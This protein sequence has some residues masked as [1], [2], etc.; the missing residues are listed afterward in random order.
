MRRV[1]ILLTGL[2]LMAVLPAV[3]FAQ[4]SYNITG[5]APLSGDNFT[6]AYAVNNSDQIVGISANVDLSGSNTFNSADVVGLLVSGSTVTTLPTLGTNQ[7]GQSYTFPTDINN[8]G[9]VV[10]ISS[11]A[12]TANGV[13]PF[14]YQ[15]GVIAQLGGTAFSSY[16]TAGAFGVNDSGVVVGNARTKSASTSQTDGFI[17]NGSLKTVG[18][19]SGATQTY[20]IGINASGVVVGGSGSNTGGHAFVYDGSIHDLGALPG[21][22]LSSATSINSQGNIVG[23]SASSTSVPPTSSPTQEIATIGLGA[24]GALGALGNDSVGNAFFYDSTTQKMTDLGTLGGGYSI[25]TDINDADDI[26]GMSTTAGGD[27]NAFLD[28]GSVMVNLNTLLPANSGWTLISADSINSN[29]DI[30]GFGQFDGNYE[31]YLLTPGGTASGGGSNGS[32]GSNGNGNSG[33]GGNG[34]GNGG[35]TVPL[36]PAVWSSLTLLAALGSIAKIKTSWGT[37]IRT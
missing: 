5:I 3:S 34:G 29:G 37:R 12:T 33:G 25:A 7:K 14:T 4:V 10:G 27:Y 28:T 32:G 36:P 30:A 8:S 19:L 15:G 17:Y 6:T 24:A 35:T 31:G 11:S 21:D 23:L 2:G 18:L 26:V 13:Y 16:Y 1:S 22:N 20:A 9:E